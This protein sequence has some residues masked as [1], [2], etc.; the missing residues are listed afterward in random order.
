MSLR[1][2]ASRT[3][4]LAGLHL[5]RAWTAMNIHLD[6]APLLGETPGVPGFFNAVTFN[7][8]TLAP[9]VGRMTA[10]ALA[11]RAPIPERFSLARFG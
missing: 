3:A 2:A 11:G 6:G 5:V 1:A 8:Y 7:G 4:A 9:I 10:D